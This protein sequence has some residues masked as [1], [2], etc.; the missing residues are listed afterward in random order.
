MA[1]RGVPKEKNLLN[2]PKALVKLVS[3]QKIV[4]ATVIATVI[5]NT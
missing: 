3:Y 5:L 1:D 2:M 4:A